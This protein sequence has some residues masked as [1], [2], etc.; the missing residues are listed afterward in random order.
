MPPEFHHILMATDLSQG[1]KESL[2]QVM[3]LVHMANA[4]ILMVNAVEVGAEGGAEATTPKTRYLQTGIAIGLAVVSAG[5]DADAATPN[6]TGNTLNRAAGGANGFKLVGITMGILIH[7][8]TFLLLY[9]AV[10]AAR[11][12]QAPAGGTGR[13]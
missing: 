13:S 8:G 12:R 11:G 9:I 3:E 1:S 7:A 5:G 6:P 10:G 4:S 2:R